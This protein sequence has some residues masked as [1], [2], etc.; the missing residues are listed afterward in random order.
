MAIGADL[1]FLAPLKSLLESCE[2]PLEGSW[3][4]LLILLSDPFQH[5]SLPH[6]FCEVSKRRVCLLPDLLGMR[7][8]VAI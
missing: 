6:A 5:R 4:W 8:V 7:T 1:C 3:L 2:C